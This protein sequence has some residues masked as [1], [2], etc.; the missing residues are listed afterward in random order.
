MGNKL[1]REGRGWRPVK[2]WVR[3]G[4]ENKWVVGICG[5][6]EAKRT[7]ENHP[8]YVLDLLSILSAG[9]IIPC[10]LLQFLALNPGLYFDLTPFVEH[11]GKKVEVD[12]GR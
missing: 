9:T 3:E 11:G 7:R 8:L 5:F 6:I 4:S 2:A 1:D 12:L 10:L